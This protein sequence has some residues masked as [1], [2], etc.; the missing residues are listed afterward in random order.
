MLQPPP[1]LHQ[2]QRWFG[3]IITNRIDSANRINPHTPSG[4]SIYEEAA[5]Y[6]A[7]SHSLKSWQRMEIYNQQYWWRLLRILQETLPLTTRLFGYRD[8]NQTIAM[9]YLERYLPDDW[10][11]NTLGERLPEWLSQYYHDE[12]KELIFNAV[13]VDLAFNR[14]FFAHHYSPLKM[15]E[16]DIDFLLEKPLALQ[17]SITLFALPYD[18]FSF[19][20]EIIEQE[21]GDYYLDHPFPLLE[22]NPSFFAVFRDHFCDMKWDHL[23]PDEFFILSQ[24][25]KGKSLEEACEPLSEETIQNKL[26]DW[27][28]VWTIDEWIYPTNKK[29]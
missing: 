2:L 18:L 9:P 29:L 3:S 14:G 10:S 8:F 19:R 27:F 21:N 5:E 26:T 13:A 4:G 12:D 11:L 17:P 15:D 20:A 22:R 7:P 25:E 28:K 6:I 1:N 16:V 23:D 24:F